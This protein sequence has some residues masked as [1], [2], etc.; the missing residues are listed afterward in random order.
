MLK[1]LK[2]NDDE[3]RQEAKMQKPPPPL[4]IATA[5]DDMDNHNDLVARLR[6]QS[7]RLLAVLKT[8]W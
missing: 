3:I 6:F 4:R 8:W 5:T 7:Q 1:L 2:Q